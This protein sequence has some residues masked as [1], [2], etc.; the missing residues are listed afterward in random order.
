MTMASTLTTGGVD[1]ARCQLGPTR[2][3]LLALL[4]APLLD[5]K[6]LTQKDTRFEAGWED[7]MVAIRCQDQAIL[8]RDDLEQELLC[9]LEALGP[10]SASSTT[11]TP[12][13]D[14]PPARVQGF[15]SIG[16]ALATLMAT[17]ADHHAVWEQGAALIGLSDAEAAQAVASSNVKGAALR[18]MRQPV[19]N[20]AH[21]RLKLVALLAV[22]EP[23][24]SSREE[25]PWREIR[26]ILLDL[27]DLCSQPRLVSDRSPSLD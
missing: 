10:L 21:L 3:A 4:P 26:L 22:H 24:P 19:H 16:E 13:D 14:A 5:G 15:I 11:T 12:T 2:R 6:G 9:G 8:H 7:L 25:T 1:D 27:D 23:G 17:L 20:L 18:L